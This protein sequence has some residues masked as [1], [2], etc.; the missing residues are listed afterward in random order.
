MI[1]ASEIL[2]ALN[3]FFAPGDVFEIRALAA[4]VPSYRREHTES[5]YFD[6]EHI[7]DIPKILANISAR[8]IYF[9][10]NPV[11]PVLLARTANRMKYAQKESTT[12]DGDIVG[13]HWLLIDCDP[14]RP[15]GISATDK[16][17]NLVIEKA[18]EIRAGLKSLGWPDPVLLDS[19]NGAQLMYCIDLPTGDDSL[20]QSCLKALAS[21]GD[22]KVQI[23]QTVHNPARIWRLPGTMNRKGDEVSGRSHRM[24]RILEIPEHLE[25]VPAEKLRIL[26][27]NATTK[28]TP[29]FETPISVNT[30]FSLDDW[31]SKY[32][33]DAKGPVQWKDAHKWVFSVCPFN[34]AHDNSSAVITR[35]ANGAIGFKCH[36]NGCVN[37]DWHALRKLKEPDI[38]KPA[39][40]FPDIDISGITSQF[41]GKAILKPWQQVS[42]DDIR[43]VL[44]NTCLGLITEQFSRV[45]NPPLPLEAALLK[46]IVIVGCALSERDDKSH[47]NLCD[48]LKIGPGLAR[49][50]ID[51]ALGQVANVYAMLAANSTSGKDIGNLLDLLAKHF[52]WGIATAG[53]A[54]GIADAL[55]AC[56]NGLITISEFSKWLN[57]NHWQHYA[58]IFLTEAFNKGFFKHSFSIR[59][60]SSLRTADYC[61]P[62]IMANIQPE[63]FE[64][65]VSKLDISDGFLG[66]FIYCRMPEF[67]GN[68][69]KIDAQKTMDNLI[70][71]VETFR[72][73]RGI[74]SV[75][76]NYF[77][78]LSEMFRK[79]SPPNLHP[80]WRRLVNEY[81]PRFAVMLS[82]TDELSMQGE[83]V[84]LTDRTWLGAEKLILWFFSHAEKMLSGIEDGNEFIKLREKLFKRVFKAVQN[85]G[86][87]GAG[88]RDISHYAGKGSTA[89][90]RLEAVNEL[91][92][93]GILYTKGEK[94]FIKH[95]PPDYC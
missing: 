10:P 31:I 65:I 73:K 4:S 25:I 28:A 38:S 92:A 1:D 71:C 43:S 23:D 22:D 78:G 59:G 33:P 51:T 35:Q 79:E 21:A 56:N 55:I 69:A 61:Y 17:H 48:Y 52:K 24:A 3:L 67:W 18:K 16:E 9:T 14:V 2:R 70:M 85:Q 34:P 75:P 30:T 41:H 88:L 47:T 68:P 12:S 53:S 32:C 91:I 74:V 27:S 54:E 42:N 37:N 49:L 40:I 58:A 60:K 46:A 39:P 8:G 72:R 11:N 80:N 57:P 50:Y 82:I 63:V 90:E 86:Q 64:S 89:K 87:S 76:E 26:A 94:Y 83:K 19:G 7:K 36:H 20:I 77:G 81:G 66:R 6:Y 13:R 95:T 45:T 93:R 62:N 5:G 44:E 15:S 29:V 84:I